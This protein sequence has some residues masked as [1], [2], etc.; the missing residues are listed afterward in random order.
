MW[1]SRLVPPPA[2]SVVK[3]DGKWKIDGAT[4]TTTE[5]GDARSID[6]A[7]DE[8]SI[9]FDSSAI[10]DGNIALHKQPDEGSARTQHRDGSTRSGCRLVLRTP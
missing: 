2:V 1:H 3:V 6:V 10:K 4:L 9:A 8:S 5:V 7:F